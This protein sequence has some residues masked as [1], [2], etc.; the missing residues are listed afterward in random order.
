MIVMHG[1]VPFTSMQIS[2][3]AMR[4]RNDAS[5]Q[6]YLGAL[7]EH[8]LQKVG[9]SIG[10]VRLK[11]AA[12]INPDAHRG[13]LG[14]RLVLSCNPQAVWESGHLRTG[15]FNKRAAFAVALD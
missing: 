7:E 6:E 5:A 3:T 1:R 2:V 14:Q 13:S 9:S 11:S 15:P 4:N 8:V 12:G 10:L